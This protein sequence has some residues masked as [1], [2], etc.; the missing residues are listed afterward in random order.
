M[1]VN[2]GRVGNVLGRDCLLVELVNEKLGYQNYQQKKSNIRR[3][4]M[5]L[6]L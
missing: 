5:N 1:N 6:I 4:L 2:I 3:K